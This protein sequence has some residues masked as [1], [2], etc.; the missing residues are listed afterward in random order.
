MEACRINLWAFFSLKKVTYHCMPLLN[1][2]LTFSFTLLIFWSTVSGQ[3]NL[4]TEVTGVYQDMSVV[5]FLQVMENK[6]GI[7]FYY[8]PAR[9]PYYKQSF[10]FTRT[11]LWKALGSFL[12]GSGLDVIKYQDQGIVLANKHGISREQVLSLI[13]NWEDGTFTKPV[14]LEPQQIS[15]L[16]G[17]SSSLLRAVEFEGTV[18]DPYSG[19]P[20]IGA[21]VQVAASGLGTS[22]D[23]NGFFQL[24]FPSGFHQVAISY[25][26]YQSID[27]RLR[28]HKPAQHDFELQVQALNLSEVVVEATEIQDKVEDTQLGVEAI[29]MR[30]V[31]ELPAFLGEADV[32]KSLERLPGVSTAG[33][34]SAGFNV[35][36]GNVDQNLVLLD[37]ALLFN[38]SHALGLFSIFNPDA[39][40][41][42]AL[43]KGNIP[44]QFGG[45]LSSVLQVNLKSGNFEKWHGSGGIGLAS[46]RIVVDGPIV[47][48]KSSLL[49]GA[50]AS[51][52]SWMLKL[53]RDENVRNSRVSFADL[54][55]KFEQKIGT[56]Q[57]IT[58]TAY[59]SYDLF[60]FA[61]DFGYNWQ[62]L[63][64]S[65]AW[66]FLID[67]NTSLSNQFSIGNYSSDQF[68]PEGPE[69]FRLTNGIQY[70]KNRTHLTFQNKS[71]FLN[72]GIDVIHYQMGAERLR[73]FDQES[74][75]DPRDLSKNQAWEF[76][77]YINDEFEISSKLTASIGLRYSYFLGIGPVTR[78]TY[79]PDR[80]KTPSSVATEDIIPKGHRESNYAGFEPRLA[81]RL[82]VAPRSSLKISY[83]RL[84]QYIHLISNTAAPTPIDIWQLSTANIA[85]QRAQN[86]AFGYF[87]NIGKSFA[88]S[89]EGFY[90]TIEN[91]PIPRNLPELI[92][93]P[94][95]ETELVPA[96]GKSYG[97]EFLFEKKE[98]DWSGNF[99]YTYS[100]SLAQTTSS[101]PEDI[102]N[103]GDWFAAS[104][105]QPHQFSLDLKRQINPVQ[106]FVVN[107][108]YKTGRP[109]TVPISGYDVTGIVVTHFSDRNVVRVPAYHR[110]DFG[111]TV[112]KS[113]SK[114]KGVKHSF[115]VSLYN[116]YS[117]KNAFS[118]FFKRDSRNI[119]RSY[120]LAVLASAFPSFTWN[121]SF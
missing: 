69:S 82:I 76:S 70:Q 53:L 33:E 65:V 111:Y 99:N 28:I 114:L 78:R 1:R 86:F 39:V 63:I 66:R 12:E 36:G 100:R 73:P 41:S 48:E 83:N 120:R 24:T 4:D 16:F 118:V 42:V 7:T 101:L 19:Q 11:P 80:V 61:S 112:D 10:T 34:A 57:S 35:R 8:H 27:L 18:T 119:Q 81:F 49:L 77:G 116:L 95:L 103:E 40:R 58:A 44:G 3:I 121:F 60:Q 13:Q 93:N 89:V 72:V 71:H 37:D 104:F 15:L 17:D 32:V 55:A 22:T 98:G 47:R 51:Y 9:I 97:V 5:E 88:Y 43:Y 54:V 109:I 64:G 113:R 75:I 87:Q 68:T 52:S 59:Y 94:Y 30:E 21:I 2:R 91:L 56:R 102:V 106:S 14:I 90:K 107:F 84:N 38:S 23:E 46:S 67:N 108:T 62:S 96:K 29:S 6:L 50:R 26:G 105:D 85:P 45:R 92:L 115:S 117:R 110:L 74:L 31:R 20:I 25:L 79:E